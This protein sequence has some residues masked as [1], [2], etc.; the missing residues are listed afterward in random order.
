MRPEDGKVYERNPYGNVSWTITRVYVL[1]LYRSR[2][3]Y[4]KGLRG[5][6]DLRTNLG[7]RKVFFGEVHKD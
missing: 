5:S 1:V 7:F 2:Y 3:V 4:W 6:K